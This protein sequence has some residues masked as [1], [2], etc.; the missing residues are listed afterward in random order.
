MKTK[1]IFPIL[2]SISWI[3]PVSATEVDWFMYEVK[4]DQCHD[5]TN[6]KGADMHPNMLIDTLGCKIAQSIESKGILML[7]CRESK[8]KIL[9]PI[10]YGNTP[11]ACAEARAI[12]K[13]VYDCSSGQ[14]ILKQQK[15]K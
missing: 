10:M 11:N 6:V 4:S 12:F 14:C 5:A 13:S 7:D 1:L 8:A 9:I 2:L 15:N 3:A